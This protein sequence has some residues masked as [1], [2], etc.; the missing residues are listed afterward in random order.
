MVWFPFQYRD[1]QAFE[2]DNLPFSS[3]SNEAAKLF[4]CAVTQVQMHDE[5][6]VFGNLEQTMSKMLEA[7]QD[8]V[9]GKTMNFAMQL[10]GVSPRI[11]PKL[12]YDVNQ[13]VA[14]AE[15]RCTSW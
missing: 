11:K 13:F 14:K 8:F 2:K 10:L 3:A 15:T 12:L 6:P 5:D 7:D 9:M 4:D 1:L